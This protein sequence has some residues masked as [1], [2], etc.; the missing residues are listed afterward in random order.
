[1]DLGSHFVHWASEPSSNW[2]MLRGGRGMRLPFDSPKLR[3][4]TISTVQTPLYYT[5]TRYIPFDVYFLIVSNPDRAT[6]GRR[7]PEATQSTLHHYFI[8]SYTDTST[9]LP[10]IDKFLLISYQAAVKQSTLIFADGSWPA[11]SQ[12]ITIVLFCSKEST[13][14]SHR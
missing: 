10:I 13:I 14:S 12:T 5:V 6:P 3:R 7:L 4:Q 8:R 9:Y 1:M 2:A 11:C